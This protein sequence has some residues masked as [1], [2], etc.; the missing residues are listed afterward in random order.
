[1]GIVRG[2]GL[3]LRRFFDDVEV[4]RSYSICSAAPD[5]PLRVAIRRVAGGTFSTWANESIAVGDRIEVMAPAGHFTH[6]LDPDASCR[7]TLLAAGSGIA[8]SPVNLVSGERSGFSHGAPTQ[9][10][11]QAGDCGNIEFGATWQRYTATIG[12]QFC[13]GPP[14]ARMLELYAIV[15]RAQDACIAAI[16]PGVNASVPHEAARAVIVE[17]GLE[18]YRVHTTGYGLAPGFPPSWGE[19]IHMLNDSPYTIEAGMVLSVE[20]PVFIPEERLGARLI[21]NVLVT[22]RGAELLTRASRDLI[23]IG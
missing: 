8:A 6:E 19:P 22:K 17:A 18:P 5:G 10:V 11:M 23:V 16:R 14:T 20:P 4:R 12:R 7:Y 1:M 9:R 15:R 2:M 13:L 21:D 3:T